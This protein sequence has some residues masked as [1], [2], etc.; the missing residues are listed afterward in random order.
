MVVERSLRVL[1][2]RTDK[3]GDL[4]LSM[5]AIRSIRESI[6]GAHLTVLASPYNAPVLRGWDV[7]DNIEIFDTC[8][9]LRRQLAVAAALRRRRF[10]LCLV[11]HPAIEAYAVA[12]MTGAPIRVGIVYARRLLE[13]VLAPV[14]LTCVSACRLERA[15]ARHSEV[16]HEIDLT[17][18]V[19][20]AAGLRWGDGELEVPMPPDAAC[21]ADDIV[22]RGGL[23]DEPLIGVHLSEKWRD[24]NWTIEHVGTMLAAL[25]SIRA[26]GA[27]LVTHGP[28]DGIIAEDLCGLPG[29]ERARG[30]VNEA[31]RWPGGDGRV[32]VLAVDFPRWAAIVSRCAVVV[33][34]DTGS[35][36][37]ASALKRPVV[38][39]YAP[40]GFA[41]NSRQFAPWRV[42]HRILMAG[43]ARDTLPAIIQAVGELLALNAAQ[44]KKHDDGRLGRAP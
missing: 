22:S 26:D 42:P 33:S 25:A 6:P 41:I 24:Q 30:E 27:V 10:D 21:W 13:R 17:R 44:P 14:L 38:A 43:A 7:P 32:R 39:V 8:W 36:H 5:P 19:V 18:M 12:R 9:P 31:A 11:L 3:V 23:P 16:P 28:S 35:L 20:E 2:I 1:V 29:F 34:R 4:L 37:L 15:A 40:K